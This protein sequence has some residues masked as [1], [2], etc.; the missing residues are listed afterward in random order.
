MHA[1]IAAS[2]RTQA[3]FAA[4]LGTSASRLSTYASGSAPATLLVRMRRAATQ[5][6]RG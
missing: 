2:G 5:W 1:L 4:E 3:Q 6:A